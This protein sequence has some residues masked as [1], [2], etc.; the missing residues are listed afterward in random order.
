LG[1]NRVLLVEDNPDHAELIINVLEAEY[2]KEVILI[3]DGKEAVD[4]FQKVCSR[5]SC[6]TSPL[7]QSVTRAEFDGDDEIGPQI[8]LIILDLNLPKVHGMDILKF[9][10]QNSMYR[11]IPVVV[12]STSSD[13]K[14]IKEAYENGANGYITKP[15]SYDGFVEKIK[16]LNNYFGEYD[17]LNNAEINT[18]QLLL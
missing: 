10:K 1:K 2:K 6:Q 12:L 11:S 3:K 5:E 7:K 8:D 18:K 4:Y 17:K 16:A 9:L 14:T 15:V 13:E